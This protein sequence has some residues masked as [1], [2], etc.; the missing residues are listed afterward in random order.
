MRQAVNHAKKTF[1]QNLANNS[2]RRPRSFW[3]YMKS[4]TSN[5]QS[6]GPIKDKGEMLTDDLK[7]AEVLN[8]FFSSVFTRENVDS[9]PVIDDIFTGEAPLRT[10]IFTEEILKEKIEGLRTM[11][12]PGPDGITPKLLQVTKDMV[13]LP[14]KIIFEKSLGEGS[15]PNDWKCANVTPIF[16]K[17]KKS[18]AGN[19][20]PV[21][22]TVCWAS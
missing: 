3:A 11:A 15:V 4:K 18:E 20:R 6:V 2:K 17:G 14:L 5:R 9:I 13:C 21:S 7:Q 19:Y 1:E 22:L 12:A 10:L 8:T 16:K